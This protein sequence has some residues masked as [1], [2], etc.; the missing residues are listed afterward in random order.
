MSVKELLIKQNAKGKI[1]EDDVG[2]CEG[3]N[4]KFKSVFPVED[5]IAQTLARWNGVLKSTGISTKDINRILKGLNPTKVHG[6]KEISPY[7][8]KICA[9]T[10]N[11]SLE[12]LFK[13]LLEKG[14]VPRQRKRGKHQ[15]EMLNG[16]PVF[17]TSV[18]N[19]VLE[20]NGNG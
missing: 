4:N 13:M 1:V 5:T 20:K 7:V 12:I 19:K 17:M 8:L 11:R 6:P 16:R 18:V 2:M 14:K 15:D 3:L 10:R 9:D